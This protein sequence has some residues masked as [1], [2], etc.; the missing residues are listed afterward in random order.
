MPRTKIPSPHDDIF[1]MIGR[2]ENLREA[3]TAMQAMAHPL[4]LKIRCLVGQNER[5]VQEIVE[6]GG[7]FSGWDSYLP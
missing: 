4:R 2:G 7:T 3:S 1:E 6:A 5:M